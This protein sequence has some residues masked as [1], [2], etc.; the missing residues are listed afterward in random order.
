MQTGMKL[1]PWEQKWSK[2]VLLVS[3][4]AA[5]IAICYTKMKHPDFGKPHA[6]PHSFEVN[7]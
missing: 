7:P 3:I 6:G 1:T 2:V 4:T 5:I